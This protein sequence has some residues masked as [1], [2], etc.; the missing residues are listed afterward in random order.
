MIPKMRRKW[1][2]TASDPQS[3]PQM[4]P[5][6]LEEW[7]G[8]YETDY[9]KGLII[10]KK[11]FLA[12]SKEKGKEDATSQVNLYKAKKKKPEKDMVS[13]VYFFLSQLLQFSFKNCFVAENLRQAGRYAEKLLDYYFNAQAQRVYWGIQSRASST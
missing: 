12:P 7:N 9:K 10:E 3:R 1:S 4:I 13:A 8:F 6:K 11:P 2:S 5:W